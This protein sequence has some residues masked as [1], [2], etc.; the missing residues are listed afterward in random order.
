MSRW[1][2]CR[3]WRP[4]SQPSGRDGRQDRLNTIMITRTALLRSKGAVFQLSGCAYEHA[5]QEGD[6]CDKRLD[7]G[8]PC[9][10]LSWPAE[11]YHAP[12]TRVR[13][14]HTDGTDVS[15]PTLVSKPPSSS[16][17]RLVRSL[18]SSRASPHLL[19]R[20]FHDLTVR[21]RPIGLVALTAPHPPAPL[22]PSTRPCAFL[23]P[24]SPHED[25]HGNLEQKRKTPA[26]T[27]LPLISKGELLSPVSCNQV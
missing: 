4:S 9:R 25:A 26:C 21:F 6:L 13:A 3:L 20:C 12:F 24:F 16:A 14:S 5:V 10:N 23:S 11:I 19:T 27:T 22:T 2:R 17:L 8:G 1:Y 18:S 15:C 7:G